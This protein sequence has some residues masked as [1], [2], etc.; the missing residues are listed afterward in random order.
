MASKT[1]IGATLVGLSAVLGTVGGLLQGSIDL[2]SGLT[3]LLT[4][5]GLVL[6]IWGIRDLPILNK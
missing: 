1:K 4:E 6:G 5:I 3:A 2:G